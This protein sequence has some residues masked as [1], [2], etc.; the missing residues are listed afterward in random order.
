MTTECLGH[1]TLAQAPEDG[2]HHR[3]SPH[4][5]TVQL[6][7]DWGSMSEEADLQ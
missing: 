1:S 4:M 5:A 3:Q 6:P 2:G 7:T